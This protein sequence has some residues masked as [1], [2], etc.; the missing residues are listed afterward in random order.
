M[1]LPGNEGGGYRFTGGEGLHLVLRAGA[2]RSQSR[3][4]VRLPSD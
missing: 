2:A 3:N 1:T 4:E